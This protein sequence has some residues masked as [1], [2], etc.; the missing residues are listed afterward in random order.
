MAADPNYLIPASI[1]LPSG[2]TQAVCTGIL[3]GVHALGS[4]DRRRAVSLT[5]TPS[6]IVYS[7]MNIIDS[8]IG[9]APRMVCKVLNASSA[10]TTSPNKG[11]GTRFGAFLFSIIGDPFPPSSGVLR[12]ISDCVLFGL[13]FRRQFN[14]FIIVGICRS[15][16]MKNVTYILP[17]TYFRKQVNA[18]GCVPVPFVGRNSQENA[19]AFP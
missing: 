6:T 19:I 13:P 7:S 9:S 10:Y 18:S 2:L 8:S 5:T 4:A 15:L 16:T 12:R 11:T 3:R 14:H 1:S 17:P